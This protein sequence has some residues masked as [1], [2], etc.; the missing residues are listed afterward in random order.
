M[1][2]DTLTPAMKQYLSLKERYQ[3]CILLFR[4]GDFYEMFFE[5]AIEASRLLE[6][7]LTS[8]DKNKADAVPLCGFPYHAAHSYIARLVEKGYKVAICEQLEDPQKAKGIVKRDVVRIITPGCVVDTETLEAKENN[9]LAAYYRNGDTGGFAF[10][11]ISTG[12]IYISNLDLPSRLQ[13]FTSLNVKEILV[14]EETDDIS[15]R[16]LWPNALVNRLKTEYFSVNREAPCYERYFSRENIETLRLKHRP[17]LL[18]PLQALLRYVEETQRE[19]LSHINYLQEFR[20][21]DYLVLDEACQATLEL[22]FNLQEGGRKGT[23]ISLLDETVTAMGGRRIRWWLRSP[24]TNPERIRERLDAVRELKE[25]HLIRTDIRHLLG[26]MQDLERIAGKIGLEAANPR[27]VIALKN[28]LARLRE[29]K[30]LL[31]P[32]GSSLL[33]SIDSRIDELTDIHNK[34][35]VALVETPPIGLKEGGIFRPGFYKELDELIAISSDGKNGIASLEEW[36]RKRT[37]ISSLKIGFN[38]VF[39]YYIEVTKANT[40]LVPPDYVR[41]QTL[42]NAERYTN[43]ALKNYEHAVLT[44]EERRKSLEY[45]LFVSFRREL[46]PHIGRIQETAS[47]LADLD[48]LATLAHVA[49][50][51][52]YTCPFIDYSPV[53]YIR[54]GRHPVIEQTMR[55]ERFVPNDTL[56][57]TEENRFLVITGPNMSGKSTYIRQVAL[58]TILAQMGSFVPAAEARIGIVDRI[59]TR[60]GSADNL[61]RGQSTF[62]VEMMEVANILKHAS[63]RSLIILDEVGRGTSTFD[64]FSI[65]WAV[66]EYISDPE[67]L[68]ARTLFATHYHQLIELAHNRSGVKNYHVAVR[69]WGDKIIFLH[70]IAEGGTSRSYGIYVA[71]LAGLPDEVINRAQEILSQLEQEETN[72]LNRLKPKHRRREK[73]INQLPLFMDEKEKIGEEIKELDISRLT[74]IEAINMINDWQT[75]L[76]K[77]EKEGRT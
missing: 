51:Y 30:N 75:R 74:P 49:E 6:I 69:E 47:A 46:I 67:R 72:H 73:E 61:A 19:H 4:M 37:G 58:I 57:D 54:E 53:I 11:D 39:G 77:E 22:F 56:L 27:D 8:R 35:D 10:T 14:P 38:S 32:L 24:L 7:A 28:S 71:K 29:I 48:A 62:M 16:R 9:F 66:A 2:R 34:I 21:T 3:D 64:G 23:L 52:D 40:H 12:E 25:K 70:R 41:K 45:D 60:I 20:P 15:I 76:K 42:V 65:A 26:Q 44:S 50:K 1:D 13:D 36:E 59:F 55:E 17:W 5:D 33:Q 63:P 43:Q 31:R 68:G 18:P